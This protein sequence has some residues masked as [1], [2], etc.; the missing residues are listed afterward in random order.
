MKIIV[1]HFDLS[2]FSYTRT[3]LRSQSSTPSFLRASLNPLPQHWV[4]EYLRIFIDETSGYAIDELSGKIAYFIMEDGEIHVSWEAESLKEKFPHLTP[5]PYTFVKSSLEDNPAMLAQN[6]LYA[7][8]LQA[9]NRQNAEMLLKGNWLYNPK[10]NGIFSRNSLIKVDKRP[11]QTKKVRAW[12]KACTEPNPEG[13]SHQKNPDYTASI[14]MEKDQDGN[15]YLVGDYIRDNEDQQIG[16]FRKKTGER[17]RMILEQCKFDGDDTTVILPKD[18]AQ[19]GDYE[20]TEHSR[21]LIEEGFVVR[22]DPSVSNKSKLLRFEPFVAA[23]E[24]GIVYI[25]ESTFDKKILDALYTELEN[26]DGDKSN[27]YHDDWA[28]ACS[29]AF[30][31]INKERSIS[32]P[33][34]PSLPSIG[35]KMSELRVKIGR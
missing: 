18:P 7:E 28:D 17:N 12:D 13:T 2:I 23:C 8:E 21:S 19:A 24:A 16:R 22:K 33:S 5:R 9:N 10:A 11:I 3:R 1:T 31:A 35:T 29:S 26:F 14:K 34:L 30:A 27:G 15:I 4:L 25:V 32:A 20:F 6:S